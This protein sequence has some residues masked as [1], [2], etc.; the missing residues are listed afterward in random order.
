MNRRT[1]LKTVVAAGAGVRLARAQ[2]KKPIMLHC[3]LQ[4]DPAR[5][6]EMVNNFRNTFEPVI[7]KQPG[8]VDVRLQK[9]RSAL[10]GKAPTS[11]NYKL[12]I[13][14]QTE[15][16]RLTWVASDDH[17]R[18]WPSIENTLTGFKFNAIL[19]DQI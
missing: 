12:L 19:Y 8:F 15:E 16:Q 6:K 2:S 1:C 9:L 18:V 7:R 3:D 11:A 4:V 17:Q 5:E 13:S 10:A 14:F